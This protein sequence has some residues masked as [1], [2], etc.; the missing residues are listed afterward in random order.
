MATSQKPIP[1]T[2]RQEQSYP[3]NMEQ[4][5]IK[6]I[7]ENE[8]LRKQKET[9]TGLQFDEA[10]RLEKMKIKDIKRGEQEDET[11]NNL[12]EKFN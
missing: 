12:V 8:E 3:T 6:L 1:S 10:I 5:S 7:L 4:L 11:V 2:T 9:L